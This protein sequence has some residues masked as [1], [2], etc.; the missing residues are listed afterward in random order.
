ME[1]N[2]F[3]EGIEEVLLGL[4]FYIILQ[5]GLLLLSNLDNC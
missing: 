3:L 5:C 1:Q 2:F 4:I